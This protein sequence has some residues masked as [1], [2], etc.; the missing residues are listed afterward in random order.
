LSRHQWKPGRAPQLIY[1]KQGKDGKQIL[2]EKI[3]KSLKCELLI[4]LTSSES[5]KKK[6]FFK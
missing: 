1:K 6:N 2:G 3:S 5:T 4:G